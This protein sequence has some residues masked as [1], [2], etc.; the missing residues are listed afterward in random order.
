[1]IWRGSWCLV[2]YGVRRKNYIKDKIQVYVLGN[3]FD[4]S[5][6]S[7]ENKSRSRFGDPLRIKYLRFFFYSDKTAKWDG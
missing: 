6:I 2:G 7:I 1:M 4:G 5:V 3:L